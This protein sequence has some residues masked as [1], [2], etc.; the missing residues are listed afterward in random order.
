MGPFS[1]LFV[2]FRSL[3]FLI[4][5]HLILGTLV[6]ILQQKEKLRNFTEDFVFVLTFDGGV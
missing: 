6:L 4:K 3:H 5:N 2:L 1:V